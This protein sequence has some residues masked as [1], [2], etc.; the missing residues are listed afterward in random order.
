ML[1]VHA[2]DV[3]GHRFS[4]LDEFM[5]FAA[6]ELVK[7][8]PPRQMLV[9]GLSFLDSVMKSLSPPTITRIDVAVRERHLERVEP[10]CGG[11]S[12]RR[13]RQV[14][15][16]VRWWGGLI[17][18]GVISRRVS[19]PS[20]LRDDVAALFERLEDHP[21]VEL[22]AQRALDPDLDVVEVDE[23]RNL[24]SCVCQNVLSSLRRAAI[25]PLNHPVIMADFR[26]GTGN[27]CATRSSYLCL[28]S[29]A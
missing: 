19:P 22:H 17:A 8:R 2:G 15:L 4:V 25:A 24:Q 3:A 1:G 5:A 29:Y 27:P 20:D 6:H 13:G 21:D 10:P 7:E 11:A 26:A 9:Y 18:I 28:T 16:A 23:N 12:C 14:A